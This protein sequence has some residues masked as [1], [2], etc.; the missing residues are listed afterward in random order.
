MRRNAQSGWLCATSFERCDN[1]YRT[2]SGGDRLFSF[3]FRSGPVA[4]APG[5]VPTFDPAVFVQAIGMTAVNPLSS[6]KVIEL[7]DTCPFLVVAF[8]SWT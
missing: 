6:D 2:G 1:G 5:S 7:S 4:I 3:S 8:G